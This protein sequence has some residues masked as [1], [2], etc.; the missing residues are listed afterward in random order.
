MKTNSFECTKCFVEKLNM[1]FYKNSKLERGFQYWCIDCCKQYRKENAIKIRHNKQNYY[2]KH[3][4]EILEQ[5]KE[6]NTLN[7]KKRVLYNKL[8]RQNNLNVRLA[9]GLR[10]RLRFVIKGI[11]KSGSAVRD[12]GCSIEYLKAYLE[13]KFQPGMT[14]DNYGKTG[15]HIDHIMPLS[16]FNLENR[17][18]FLKACHYTNL[19]PLWFYQNLSKQNKI[20]N[21]EAKEGKREE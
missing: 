6:Y 5:K 12:L 7:R 1:H 17:E 15:W 14:W 4:T 19:Q 16:R 10:T 8:R 21:Q 2:S 9:D 18:E 11:I 3:R 13:S 20:L